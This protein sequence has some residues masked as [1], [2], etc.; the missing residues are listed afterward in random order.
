VVCGNR[1]LLALRESGVQQCAV[2]IRDLSDDEAA[3]AQ[4]VENLQR[5]DVPPL[6]EG[7]AFTALVKKH[8]LDH[9]AARIGKTTA[10]VRRR[11]MLTR[12]TGTARKL[13]QSGTLPIKAAELIAAVEDDG[14]RKKLCDGIDDAGIT[15]GEVAD[16]L[17]RSVLQ[18][19]SAAPFDK[20]KVYGCPH[21]DGR[22][23]ADCPFNTGASKGQLFPELAKEARCLNSRCFQAKADAEFKVRADAHIAK[24]GGALGEKDARQC[25]PNGYGYFDNSHFVPLDNVRQAAKAVKFEIAR[26]DILIAQNPHTKQ[27]HL[28]VPR[29]VADEIRKR[30]NGDTNGK[31]GEEDSHRQERRRQRIEGEKRKALRIA[32][33][34][35]F[36]KVTAI[37]AKLYPALATALA[38]RLGFDQW[39]VVLAA[40]GTEKPKGMTWEQEQRFEK[41]LVGGLAK[42][43][44]AGFVLQCA[45]LMAD[46][47]SVDAATRALA[48]AAGIN[49]RKIEQAID[50]AIKEQFTAPKSRAKAADSARSRSSEASRTVS[51]AGQAA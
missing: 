39:R 12:L 26:K 30:V 33:A 49:R 45:A 48:A 6:E 17:Q 47:F 18:K 23:C 44:L 50:D 40:R 15:P 14:I 38:G 21:E 13:L 1:R 27:S 28:V 51:V 5:E 20:T 16:Y 41:K 2:T 31:R 11:M 36:G 43:E 24:G 10:F 19:L 46:P 3:D 37:E 42:G 25:W 34:K 29:P 4:Q 9:V 22:A 7:E 8:G 32:Y 35:A